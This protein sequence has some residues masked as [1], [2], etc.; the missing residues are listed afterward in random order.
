MSLRLGTFFDNPEIGKSAR[1][2]D[3][4]LGEVAAETR[5]RRVNNN[6]TDDQQWRARNLRDARGQNN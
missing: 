3:A 5:K 2:C 1:R 4:E 6:D